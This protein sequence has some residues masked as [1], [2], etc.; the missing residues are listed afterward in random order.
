ME[1]E[2]VFKTSVFGGFERQ[3]VLN[4]VDD[5]IA[6]QQKKE[7]ELSQRADALE[8]E[9]AELAERAGEL[10]ARVGDLEAQA[11]A[12]EAARAEV[13]EKEARLTLLEQALEEERARAD[14]LEKELAQANER[15]RKYDEIIAQVGLV[16]VEAQNQAEAV[17]S[18]ARAQA[19]GIARE[20]MDHI[21]GLCRRVDD[22]DASVGQLRSF[23]A[24]TMEEVDRRIA[25]LEQA[26]RETQGHLYISAGVTAQNRQP[27]GEASGNDP[28]GDDPDR[29]DPSGED[30]AFFAPAGPGWK[31]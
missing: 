7:T 19:D 3:S 30:G 29:D 31:S 23:A 2:G 8:A 27:D 17:V 14:A 16:M 13:R 26:V 20:S 18:R 10:A 9:R 28:A 1:S 22:V 12:G 11:K 15:G 4:Y 5:L 24:R 21:Y 6:R 25:D